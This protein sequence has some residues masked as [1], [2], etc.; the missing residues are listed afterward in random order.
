MELSLTRLQK[1]I[2]LAV[3]DGLI[4]KEI[5]AQLGVTE[6]K[7]KKQ[8]AVI[9]KKLNA[10]NRVTAILEAIRLDIIHDRRGKIGTI[11]T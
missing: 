8:L 9:Y 6:G 7:I 3:R 2:L 4:N 10:P 11:E 1:N 5:A